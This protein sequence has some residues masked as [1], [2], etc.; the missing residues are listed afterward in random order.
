MGLGVLDQVHANVDPLVAV[1]TQLSSVPRHACLENVV[2]LMHVHALGTAHVQSADVI[3][4]EV[5]IK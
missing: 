5:I 2:A 4:L 3:A 1:E